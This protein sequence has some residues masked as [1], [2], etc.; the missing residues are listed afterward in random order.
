MGVSCKGKD[1]RFAICMN[2]E[3]L[4]LAK[5]LQRPCPSNLRPRLNDVEFAISVAAFDVLRNSTHSLL[6]IHSNLADSSHDLVCKPS[7]RGQLLVEV[8]E[9]LL[10]ILHH[11][12]TVI[13]T[14]SRKSRKI[15]PVGVRPE[16]EP[17]SE[18]P[19]ALAGQRVHNRIAGAVLLH[20]EPEGSS[21]EVPNQSLSKPDH[22]LGVHLRGVAIGWVDRVDHK[23]VLR[24]HQPLDQHGHLH[25]V[26]RDV[27]LLAAP[28][29]PFVPLGRP[30]AFQS[31][32]GFVPLLAL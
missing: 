32:E 27:G 23:G 3:H 8:H 24:L 14:S 30:D 31:S 25:L 6:D 7:V 2:I 12:Y 5:S 13:Q 4:V 11:R 29:G 1:C 16:D 28:E 15:L 18:E 10:G 26:D 19:D 21:W 20:R 22:N 17:A 9:R